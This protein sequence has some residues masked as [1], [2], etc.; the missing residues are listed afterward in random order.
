M[1]V[2]MTVCIF[3]VAWA[4]WQRAQNL[5]R[6]IYAEHMEDVAITID[7]TEYRFRDIAFYLAHQEMVVDKQARVYDMDH[8]NKYWNVHTNGKFVRVEARDQAMN[9]AVHDEIFYQIATEEKLELTEEEIAYMKNQKNDFWDDLEEEGR[10]RLGVTEDEIEQR[11]WRMAL[12]EKA[13]K[14]MAAGQN[15]EEGAYG[16]NGALYEEL[17][18]THSVKINERLWK[19]LNFGNIIL[20]Y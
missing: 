3:A 11:F 10:Q 13:Q 1:G 8:P 17:L 6:V 2:S 18:K 12:A 5:Q 16:M 7:G 20:S 19:R 14:I 9:M 15:A 4:V